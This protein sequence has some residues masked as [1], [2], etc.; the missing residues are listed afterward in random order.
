MSGVTTTV[1]VTP[2][3]LPMRAAPS[4]ASSSKGARLLAV[5]RRDSADNNWPRRELHAERQSL[6]D[7]A[8][9]EDWSV[10]LPADDEAALD[11]IEQRLQ[12]TRRMA[13]L[14]PA[15]IEFADDQTMLCATQRFPG[16]PRERQLEEK[17]L[18]RWASQR[19][20]KCA[21]GYKTDAGFDMEWAKNFSIWT[22]PPVKCPRVT[23]AA[24]SELDLTY[25][26]EGC[27][28]PEVSMATRRGH[29]RR[30]PYLLLLDTWENPEDSDGEWAVEQILSSHQ[31]SPGRRA[32]VQDT[33]SGSY[34]QHATG[35]GR[36]DASYYSLD[37][38]AS[39][40]RCNALL[41]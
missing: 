26:C 32:A 13:P 19:L 38:A 41:R 16:V 7:S 9:S 30:C 40:A 8:P 36:A 11:V 1:P 24:L 25:A 10:G 6:A 3:T 20:G 12:D 29:E 39:S 27:G 2:R 23:H 37:D 34:N 4:T 14:V 5:N 17:M 31:A 28:R 22:R 21:A 33:S 18:A 35:Y 15:S